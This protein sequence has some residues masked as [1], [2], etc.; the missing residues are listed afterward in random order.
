MFQE[1]SFSPKNPI[2]LPTWDIFRAG[3][4]QIEQG[5]E[6]F[7]LLAQAEG[8]LILSERGIE[9]I[10][11]QIWDRALI[12]L[13]GHEEVEKR[14]LDNAAGSLCPFPL[15]Q[16][17]G[18]LDVSLVGVA[19]DEDHKYSMLVTFMNADCALIL[20]ELTKGQYP[21]CFRPVILQSKQDFIGI[22]LTLENDSE[23]AKINGSSTGVWCGYHPILAPSLEARSFSPDNLQNFRSSVLF[24]QHIRPAGLQLEE[25][26]ERNDRSKVIF[27]MNPQLRSLDI[28]ILPE[29]H[30]K[31]VAVGA[32]A[33]R[34]GFI[35][36]MEWEHLFPSDHRVALLSLKN[37]HRSFYDCLSNFET[38]SDAGLIPNETLRTALP[39]I[40]PALRRGIQLAMPTVSP[41]IIPNIQ[42]CGACASSFDRHSK[43]SLFDI[44]VMLADK[45]NKNYIPIDANTFEKSDLPFAL[46]FTMTTSVSRS[47]FPGSVI[48]NPSRKFLGGAQYISK[49]PEGRAG[50][51][52]LHL[53]GIILPD[54]TFIH[55]L[56]RL[57]TQREPS[58]FFPMIAAE[59]PPSADVLEI[60]DMRLQ[61]KADMEGFFQQVNV[62]IRH[63]LGVSLIAIVRN[64]D[65]GLIDLRLGIR[66]I[67]SIDT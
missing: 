14:R 19:V 62:L 50:R 46:N 2:S 33:Q 37:Q 29:D 24:T 39:L 8:S 28:A 57:C 25:D 44:F 32:Y 51:T 67:W 61:S 12:C 9:K 6:L 3:R 23:E 7:S 13:A 63:S 58:L 49:K 17:L 35:G 42:V 40:A 66:K 10:D 30:E 48:K 45:E 4:T 5:Q 26:P 34:Y 54:A 52:R 56:D 55:H 1:F 43:E 47:L 21:L 31:P 41:K 65:T 16:K 60:S 59:L 36:D 38:Q 27:A 18:K 22:L 11:Y 20:P 15:S 64:Q 53:T